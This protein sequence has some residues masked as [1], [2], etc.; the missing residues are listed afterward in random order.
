MYTV[1]AQCLHVV[2]FCL[3]YSSCNLVTFLFLLFNVITFLFV[4]LCCFFCLCHYLCHHVF[5]FTSSHFLLWIVHV[6]YFFILYCSCRCIF[7][8]CYSSCRYIFCLSVCVCVICC[9]ITFF[10]NNNFS[11]LLYKQHVCCVMRLRDSPCVVH[12]LTITIL[13]QNYKIF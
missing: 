12:P 6:I 7:C 13:E 3:S 9:V 4:W 2:A 8:L 1:V 5:L 11:R 10:F